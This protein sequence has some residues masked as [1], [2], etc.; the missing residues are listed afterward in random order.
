MNRMILALVSAILLAALLACGRLP[1]EVAA[2]NIARA[3]ASNDQLVFT[4]YRDGNAEVYRILADGT[5]RTRLTNDAAGDGAPRWSPDGSRIAFNSDRSG[6]AD[7]Y[8]MNAD[9]TAVVRL[10]DHPA[11]D[12]FP[13][14]SP[15]GSR[16]AFVSFREGDRGL[17]VMN[18]DG[19]DVTRLVEQPEV[20]NTVAWRPDG[21]EI[22]FGGTTGSQD[23]DI[24]LVNV[25]GTNLRRLTTDPAYD[26]QPAWSPD[27]TRIVFMSLRDGTSHLLYTMSADGSNVTLLPY[28]PGED[29]TPDWS[30]DGRRIAFT[31][32]FRPEDEY[33]VGIADLESGVSTK[34][35]SYPGEGEGG[36]N[37]RPLAAIDALGVMEDDVQDLGWGETPSNPLLA[38]LERVENS[39]ANGRTDAA[40]GQLEA[41]IHQVEAQRGKNLSDE[42]ADS[43]VGYARALLARL[44]SG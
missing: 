14:W 11:I 40:V 30:P 22:A 44:G 34:V 3:S 21:S 28:T 12:R 36:P 37:W 17:F 9:G 13:E 25:N 43:L 6:N 15:D 7:I 16:I 41:F 1:P 8:V 2:P 39:L 5:G 19:S 35:T 33:G 32:F 20:G 18:E 27:G 42:A 29:N 26:G 38:L 24:Y 10:T 31:R 23:N 4:S